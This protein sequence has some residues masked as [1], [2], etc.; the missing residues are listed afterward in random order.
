MVLTLSE[1]L[2]EQ[3]LPS[4]RFWFVLTESKEVQHFGMIDC[5]KHH[6]PEFL[7]QSC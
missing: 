6:K 2:K 5:I 3:P 1:D 7:I 4:T